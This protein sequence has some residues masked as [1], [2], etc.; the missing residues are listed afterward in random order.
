MKVAVVASTLA[1]SGIEA[2]TTFGMEA[3]SEAFRILSSGLYSDKI[4]AVLREVSCNALDAHVVA[5]T[6]DLPIEVQL[7]TLL[8]HTLRIRDYGPGLDEQQM[9]DTYTRYFKSDKRDSNDLIGGKG[10]GSKSPFCYTD[11]FNVTVAQNGEKRLY[12]AHIGE[13]GVPVLSLMGRTS[14]DAD[15]PHGLEVSF[16]VKPKDITEFHTKAALIFR[17]FRVLPRIIG[18]VAAERVAVVLEGETFAIATTASSGCCLLMGNVAYPLHPGAGSGLSQSAAL[19]LLT[20]GLILKAPIGAVSPTASREGLEYSPADRVAIRRLL[21]GA[22]QEL[23]EM[24]KSLALHE[25]AT[26]WQTCRTIRS[27]ISAAEARPL[28]NPLVVDWLFDG[29]SEPP[30]ILDKIKKRLLSWGIRVPAEI[31]SSGTTRVFAYGHHHGKDRPLSRT[32]IHKGETA[33]NPGLPLELKYSADAFI[34][35]MDAP[36]ADQRIRNKFRAMGEAWKAAVVIGVFGPD[37]RAEAMRISGILEGIEVLSA[38]SW[39]APAK[40]ENGSGAKGSASKCDAIKH[41]TKVIR[42]V[43]RPEGRGYLKLAKA[44]DGFDQALLD[45]RG[46]Y[47]VIARDVRPAFSEFMNRTSAPGRYITAKMLDVVWTVYEEARCQGVDLPVIDGVLVLANAQPCRSL[48]KDGWKDLV[49]VLRER[50]LANRERLVEGFFDGINLWSKHENPCVWYGMDRFGAAA[51]LADLDTS[52]QA[53]K[54]C[55][56]VVSARPAFARWVEE[57]R[58]LKEGTRGIGPESVR[59]QVV[60][61]EGLNEALPFLGQLHSARMGYAELTGEE[62]MESRRFPMLALLDKTWFKHVLCHDA[63]AEPLHRTVFM[64]QAALSVEVEG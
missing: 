62:R 28:N 36:A 57:F 48:E 39:P 2:Q 27:R 3:T 1:E 24:L 56:P 54:A 25:E 12:V 41:Y 14:A 40:P 35:V 60:L 50:L 58:A 21:S 31:G 18:G 7:P 26:E 38:S 47:Y 6:P 16:P 29:G 13:Q 59:R 61:R 44:C 46:R 11:S 52:S 9:I 45:E 20:S 63:E 32:E 15:W 43:D 34:V 53:W 10:L 64:L 22:M 19:H 8:D 30:E 49:S 23:R 5:G 17:W 37:A 33:I 55:E 51:V 4:S 42:E